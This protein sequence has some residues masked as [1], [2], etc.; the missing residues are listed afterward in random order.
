MENGKT[1]LNIR[2][3]KKQVKGI[4]LIA[5]VVTII[6]LLILAGVA[7][8]LT[9][10]QNGI[11]ARAQNAV[12]VYEQAAT[13]E[14]QELGKVEDIMD[15]YLNGNGGNQGGGGE[16]NTGTTVE[17]AKGQNK[18]FENDTTITDSC[19]PANSI[20]VPEG[21]KIA[22]DS[23]LTVE[24]G[25][26]I[27]DKD[28]NQF[29]WIPAKTEAEGG[30]TINLSTGGTEKIVYQRTD[31]GK[32]HGSYS[33]YSETMPSDEEASVNAWGGYYIG[34]FEA[35][36]KEATD[37]KSMREDYMNNQLM[38][39]AEENG[40]DISNPDNL[41]E[42]QEQQLNEKANE[43]ENEVHTITIRK[44]QAPYNII[45]FANLKSLAE[46]MDTVQ[47]YTTATT[48]LV[49]SYA[50]DT[51]ISYIQ[52]NN[53][54]YGTNS[55]EGNYSNSNSF[56]YTDIAGDEQTGPTDELI[57]TGQTTAVSNIYDMGGNL[58]EYTTGS[59]SSEYGPYVSRGG[60]YNI[61]YDVNPA[62]FRRG[63]DG[64]AISYNGFRVTLY[65]K[66]ES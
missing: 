61:D 8:S 22:K 34:R 28:G 63:D 10:G 16:Y 19:T 45:T 62:G 29:V 51:A 48:K 12:N 3:L 43:I 39:Y 40:I 64:V 15:E 31:F 33:N 38:K 9:I 14:Q 37:A 56:T 49:S 44:S 41:T 24:D 36:D 11:F 4:T 20:R 13:N 26:V 66:T 23:A 5:L 65:C 47:G 35:G 60:C 59:S 7:I 54:D 50:W 27:E 1:S 32:R 52:I 53:S 2:K 58:Y 25:I 46:G 17:E 42:E 55:P 30:A 18:P 57:P 6:V 21:F